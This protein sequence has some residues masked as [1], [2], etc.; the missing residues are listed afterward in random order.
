MITFKCN[1]EIGEK[2]R[3]YGKSKREKRGDRLGGG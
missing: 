2:V 3:E 1:N